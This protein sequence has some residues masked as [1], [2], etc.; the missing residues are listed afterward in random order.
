[1]KNHVE[2]CTQNGTV[3]VIFLRV[4]SQSQEIADY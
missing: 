4:T 2:L 3:Y 1:M